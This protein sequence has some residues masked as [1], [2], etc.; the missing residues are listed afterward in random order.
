MMLSIYP[1]LGA[2]LAAAFI[3]IYPL[4]ESVLEKISSELAVFR[5][6]HGRST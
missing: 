4:N 3:F 2:L 1:G 5:S 6:T